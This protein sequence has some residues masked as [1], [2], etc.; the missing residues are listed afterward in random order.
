M[1]LDLE[2]LKV[3]RTMSECPWF[4]GGPRGSREFMTIMNEGGCG[5]ANFQVHILTEPQVKF[6][7]TECAV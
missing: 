4:P 2:I 3:V 6:A 7:V 1:I 5:G